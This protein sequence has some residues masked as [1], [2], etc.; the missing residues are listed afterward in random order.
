MALLVNE[1]VM[2]WG[3]N[4]EGELG[5]GGHGGAGHRAV[6]VCAPAPEPC[7][8]SILRGVVAISGGQAF[9]LA[10]LKSGTVMAWG[11]N[12]YGQ[13]GDGSSG[14]QSCTGGSS[15]TVSCSDVPVA[16]CAVGKTSCT[17]TK[18]ELRGVKEISAGTY[19]AAALLKTGKVVSWGENKL[20]ELGD[21][22]GHPP[23]PET[24][25]GNTGNGSGPC[26]DKPVATKGLKDVAQVSAGGFFSL[27]LLQNATVRAW[28]DDEFGQLGNG[29]AANPNPKPLVVCAVGQTSCKATK[30]ELK[31]VAEVSAGGYHALA[32]LK[33]DEGV[34]S[35]GLN[36][37]G[38]LGDPPFPEGYFGPDECSTD[39][40]SLKPVQ[41][42][43][44]GLSPVT[45]V[46]AGGG[47]TS[48]A[49]Q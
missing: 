26:S 31:N 21:G 39:P 29:I 48:F 30:D 27:A 3:E 16:V 23:G 13:L 15:G 6:A 42:N 22:P 25:A 35:W 24:C 8:G 28:G 2:A 19:Y 7:P 36:S 20:G 43:G 41:V 14:G 11:E 12:G 46:S 10:L 18:D 38:N 49:L 44:F 45:A 17:P 37:Q 33:N 34:L 40:C 32:L 47:N 4:S 5:D 1:T 9:S